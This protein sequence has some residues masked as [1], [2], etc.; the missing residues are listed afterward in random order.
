M[1]ILSTIIANIS[2]F[3]NRQLIWASKLSV[4]NSLLPKIHKSITFFCQL[5]VLWYFKKIKNMEMSFNSFFRW[6]WNLLG[7]YQSATHSQLAFKDLGETVALRTKSQLALTLLKIYHRI[8]C[9]KYDA[10]D[11]PKVEKISKYRSY[12][13]KDC[14]SGYSKSTFA[15]KFHIFTPLPP[16]FIPICFTYTPFPQRTFVLVTPPSLLW[17]KFPRRWI[18]KWITGV[19][20]SSA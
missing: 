13:E 17:K 9:N 4:L 14:R 6:T 5:P 7:M 12:K 19:W 15:Q 1:N 8:V 10:G 3:I 2:P 20:I 18:F 16:L 11:P